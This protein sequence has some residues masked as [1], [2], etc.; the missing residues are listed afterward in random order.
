M[1]EHGAKSVD[2]C[3][4]HPVLVNDAVLKIM[5]AGARDLSS[6]DTLTSD[7]SCISLAKLIADALR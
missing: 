2:V 6:T 3:C 1:K 4:V 7:V 5:A